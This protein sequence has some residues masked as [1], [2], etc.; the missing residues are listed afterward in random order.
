[1]IFSS[2]VF[3]FRFLPV[4]FLI[5]LLSPPK[6]RNTVLLL[7]S[8]FFYAW[9]EPRFAFLILLSIFVNYFL[10]RGISHF[11]Q[12]Q[13][14]RIFFLIIACIYNIGQ[15]LFFKYSNFFVDNFC[16]LTG[17]KSNFP[18]IVLPLGI[19]FYTFQ[20]LSY[21]IDV[22]R[23]KVACESSIIDLGTY[24]CMFPQLIAGPIVVYKSVSMRLKQP[25][26]RITTGR[27]EEGIRVFILGLGSKVL[28]ANNFGQIWDSVSGASF[29]TISTA[30]AW[31]GIA[32]YTLQIFFDFNGYSLMAIGLGK[33]LGF[34]FPQNFRF[35]YSAASVTDFWKRWHITLTSWFREYVYIPLGGNRKGK[36]RMYLNMLIVWLITG[37][38]H[39]AGWNFILWGLYYF[40]LLSIERMFFL[41]ILER[42][43][44]LSR[45]YTLVA[46]MSG[47]VIFA[48]SNLSEIGLYFSRMF[49]PHGGTEYMQYISEYWILFIL[50]IIFSTPL[51]LGWYQ[52]Y[53]KKFS[54]TVLLLVIFWASVVSLVDS[55]YN[56]FLYFRF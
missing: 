52:K 38:W 28:L 3:I 51:L 35:P 30:T 47:W 20:I 16:T 4:F 7:G 26:S 27:L 46:V 1:M 54:V 44:V 42:S 11:D 12:N 40:V 19:S 50:G 33:M 29:D 21:E 49:I 6:F 37:F 9:G 45:I 32:A 41:K 13:K 53:K 55:V 56:P 5:Y 8:L 24:L 25:E 36:I 43:N 17:M 48:L 15:L 39:G 14:M 31:I 34:Q 18:K 23:R 2:L 10:A 22:Y